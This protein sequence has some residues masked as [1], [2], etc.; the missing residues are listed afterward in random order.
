MDDAAVYAA[1]I[2]LC[3]FLIEVFWDS[4]S[5]EF[6]KSLLSGDV[7][8]PSD[9]VS[10]PLDEGFSLLEEFTEANSGRTT[11]TVRDDLITEYTQVF[12]GPRPPVLAHETY[13]RD[14]TEFIGEGLA[15][16]E[17]SY[18]A[19]GWTPP[20]EYGEE[21]DFVAVELAFLRHLITRQQRGAEETFGYERVFID[22]HLDH[23]IDPFVADLQ[24]KTDSKLY[25]AAAALTEGFVEFEDELV[26][27]MVSD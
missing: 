17:A 3:D 26:A 8:V 20:E 18:S 6:V 23:W 9:P 19:A 11:E 27:Q 14:D 22:E 21:N 25:R 7:Q 1:R 2:E 16:V 4:P 13:Y 15:E 5:E 24:E 10:D 12:V